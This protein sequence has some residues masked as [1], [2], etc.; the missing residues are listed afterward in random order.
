LAR[1][2]TIIRRSL[3]FKEEEISNILKCKDVEI[4]EAKKIVMR[5]GGVVVLTSNEFEILKK[6]VKEQ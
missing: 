3:N 2:N 6:L 5:N 1:I 4:D